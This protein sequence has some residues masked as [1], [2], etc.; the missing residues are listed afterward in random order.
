MLA[1]TGPLSVSAAESVLVIGDSIAVGTASVLKP[2]R[3]AAVVG[4]NSRTIA[5]FDGSGT[6]TQMVISTGSND[7]GQNFSSAQQQSYLRSIRDKQPNA[8]TVWI[9]PY[10]AEMKA[11]VQAVAASYG[12]A[13]VDLSQLPSSDG[14]HPRS[15]ST[16]ATSVKTALGT[17]GAATQGTNATGNA[18]TVG[19]NDTANTVGSGSGF[20]G[21]VPCGNG[22]IDS[23][24]TLC[25]FVIGM[26]NIIVQIRN[27][28]VFI[29]LVVITGMAIIYIVSAGNEKMITLAKNG[30]KATVIGILVVLFAWFI[31]NVVMFFI[32]N[33]KSDLGIGITFQGTNGFVFACSTTS[34]AG[35]STGASSRTTATGASGGDATTAAT[36]GTTTCTNGRCAKDAS[37][38]TAVNSNT[39]GVP[40]NTL[41]S[42]IEGG[43]GCNKSLSTDGFGSCGYSQALPR[44]RT[45]CGITGTA[46]E[47]CAKI[48]KDVQMDMNCAAKL[49]K[50][51]YARCG[52]GIQDVASCYNTCCAHNCAKAT[53]NYCGRV[54]AYYNTCI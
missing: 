12:D 43:E 42:I 51:N 46:A 47:T 16:L 48:Q 44:I 7:K 37:V 25:H 2:T 4:A 14:L 26:A 10:D 13:T 9:L 50:S 38:V 30:I 24:C 17:T 31:V 40:A 28:M 41:L 29:G 54:Q 49:I 39:S 33:A 3:T 27:L 36:V 11:A 15:Y 52:T 18:S 35:T 5:G 34:R 1:L 21:L 8:K 22:G 53:N 23:A 32:F 45:W 19:A 6:F 20:F